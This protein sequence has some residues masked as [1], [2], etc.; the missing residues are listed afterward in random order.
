MGGM[1]MDGV[2]M[3]GVTGAEA[4]MDIGPTAGGQHV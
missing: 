1:T 3:A 2:K 4:T